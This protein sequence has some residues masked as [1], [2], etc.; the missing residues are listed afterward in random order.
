MLCTVQSIEKIL[1]THLDAEVL[2][3]DEVHEFASGKRTVAAIQGFENASY[4]LGFTATVP[5]EPIK[6]YTLEG[7]LGPKISSVSTSDLGD[8]GDLAKP[9]IQIITQEYTISG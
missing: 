4:R 5:K 6:L 9:I 1:D 8:R 7:A 3:I 2:M